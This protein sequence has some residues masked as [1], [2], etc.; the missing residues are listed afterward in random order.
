[1]N[2]IVSEICGLPESQQKLHI[3]YVPGLISNKFGGIERYVLSVARQCRKRGHKFSIIWETKPESAQ[4]VE[5]L[6]EQ[7]A[8]SYIIP[9]RGRKPRFFK[10][11]H[12]WF[13]ET[14]PDILHA[15]LETSAILSLLAA[16][17]R[18]IPWPVLTIHSGISPWVAKHK[19]T[20]KKRITTLIKMTLAKRV[21][22]I[23]KQVKNDYTRL[24]LKGRKMEVR[25]LGIELPPTDRDKASVRREFGL[26]DADIV[27]ATTAFHDPVKG[28]DILLRA[29]SLLSE[30]HPRLRLLQIGSEARRGQTDALKALAQELGVDNRIVWAGLRNDVGDVLLGADIYCQPSR[31]EGLGLAILEAMRASLPVVASDVGGISEIVIPGQTGILT[32]PEDPQSLADALSEMVEHPQEREKLARA[33]EKLSLENFNLDTQ[34]AKLV[35]MYEGWMR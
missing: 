17:L 24:N 9:V 29:L 5:Q 15:H 10:E 30:Q 19:L 21:F 3:A 35:E 8:D 22:A 1:L 32:P 31:S 27:I 13:K 12:L 16:R 4:F 7:Q 26:N 2:V 18:R 14:R 11:I 20:V 34:T 23:S 6:E 28:M 25:Y 33:G